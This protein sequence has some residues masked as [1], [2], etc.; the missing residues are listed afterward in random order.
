MNLPIGKHASPTREVP[1]MTD[2]ESAEV[3]LLNADLKA[4]RR[5]V[6]GELTR[7]EY[8]GLRR[9]FDAALAHVR[10]LTVAI[11]PPSLHILTYQRA[12]R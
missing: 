12:P 3:Y 10:L 7:E 5:V 2:L 6:A 1:A 4:K 8:E 9:H 11:N